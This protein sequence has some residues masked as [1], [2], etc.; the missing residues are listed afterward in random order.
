MLPGSTNTSIGAMAPAF[1]GACTFTKEKK[2]I[3]EGGRG[4][5]DFQVSRER[6]K[7]EK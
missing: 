7:M 2:D 6:W 3:R 4:G 5:G 1:A